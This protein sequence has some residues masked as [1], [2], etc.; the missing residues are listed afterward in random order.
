MW[1]GPSRQEV[2]GVRAGEAAAEPSRVAEAVS[3]RVVAPPGQSLASRARASVRVEEFRL[4]W[5]ELPELPADEMA[6]EER[7]TAGGGEDGRL[8][9]LAEPA[10]DAVDGAGGDDEDPYLQYF[11]MASWS[12]AMAGGTSR[13]TACCE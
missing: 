8:G 4:D 1:V 6:L 7:R 13:D 11:R 3:E 2:G 12:R 5:L 9:G 10:Q